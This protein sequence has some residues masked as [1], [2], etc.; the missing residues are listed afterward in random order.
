MLSLSLILLHLVLVAAD[1]AYVIDTS[2]SLV[3]IDLV[4]GTVN[5]GVAVLGNYPNDIL[6]SD[7]FVYVVNSGSDNSALQRINVETWQIENLSIG[8]GYNCWGERFLSSDTLLI[9]ATLNNSLVIVSTEPLSVLS[10]ISGVGPCPEWMCLTEGFAW[11]ACGGWGSDNN[12]VRVDLTTMSVSDTIEVEVNCQSVAYDGVDEL[13]VVNSG[14]Y[15]NNEG[16]ISIINEASGNV[17]EN[18]ITG[19]FP[20]TICIR[21]NKAYIGDGWGPGVYVI[22]TDTH[23]VLHNSSNPIFTGGTG[24]DIDSSGNLFISDTMNSQVRVYDQN[25]Q[26]LISYSVSNPGALAVNG[27][28]TGIEINDPVQ[29]AE[30]LMVSPIPTSSIV[31]LTG[32]TPGESI[33]VF[34]LTGRCMGSSTADESGTSILS[35]NNLPEGIYTVVSG[36]LSAR[37]TVLR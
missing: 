5:P 31:T 22:T 12:L 11:V 37:I 10:E 20:S 29:A 27:S 4:S 34:D 36:N 19:G 35:T 32:A 6:Y 7:G 30:Y 18:L 16:S 25:D 21:D 17:T 23:E 9:S 26:L 24:F 15:G 8:T 33:L 1:N 3:E 14:T 28:L 13:F 2:G